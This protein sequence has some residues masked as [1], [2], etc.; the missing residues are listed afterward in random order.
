MIEIEGE[1]TDMSGALRGNQMMYG[2]IREGTSES[3]FIKCTGPAN[4]LTAQKDAFVAFCESI[5]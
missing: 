5:E 4:V 2:V 1:Y 3:L